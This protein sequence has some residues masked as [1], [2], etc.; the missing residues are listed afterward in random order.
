MFRTC[1]IQKGGSHSLFVLLMSV[2]SEEINLLVQHYLQELG[3]EHTAFSFGCESKIP[4]KE[5]AK[6]EIPPGSL[7]YLVQKGIMYAQM[8]AAADEAATQPETLFGHQL[9]LLKSNIKQSTEIAEELS[10]AT[11]RLRILPGEDQTEPLEFYLSSQSSLF[12]EGHFLSALFSA[13]NHESNLLATCSAD[14]TV[15]VWNFVV[16]ENGDAVVLDDPSVFKPV[17]DDSTPADV[18]CL[19]WSPVDNILAVGT[20]SGIICLYK[21]GNEIL[22]ISDQTSPIVSLSFTP[23]GS[24]FAAGASDGTVIISSLSK[25]EVT[26]K[27]ENDL[28]DVK[29]LSDSIL[30]VA[31]GLNVYKIVNNSDPVSIYAGKNSISQLVT[32]NNRDFVLCGDSIGNVILFDK[33]LNVI[34]NEKIH[35]ACCTAVTWNSTDEESPK[36][37]YTTCGSDGSIEI[38]SVDGKTKIS[39][40]DNP[41]C[42][43][44]IAI[45]PKNRYFVTSASNDIISLYSVKENKLLLTFASIESINHMSWSPDGRFLAICMNNGQV[46]VIDFEQIC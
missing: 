19:A 42:I 46:S 11:R 20:F 23:N 43:H 3:F 17:T 35:Q 18:T 14:G 7:V 16:N 2:S 10:S 8:E 37:T 38:N 5:I 12:L 31:S 4:T 30:L 26:K 32:S 21:D 1:N 36:D 39:Y 28:M 22:R 9:N 13:W 6:R 25:V 41:Y 45:D 15:C 27:T 44:V 33:D 29:Y 24:A 40:K 34:K